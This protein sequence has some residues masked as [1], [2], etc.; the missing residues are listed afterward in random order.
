MAIIMNEYF[1]CGC[2]LG[3]WKITEDY[4]TLLSKITLSRDEL[5]TL[6]RF[7]HANRK[8]EWLSVR[9]LLSEMTNRELSIYYNGN[10]KPFIK[11][12]THMISIS[13]S[14]DLT[15]ILLNRQKKV[16]VDLEYMTNRIYRIEHKFINEQDVLT[17]DRDH[18]RQHLYLHWCAKET[19]YKI[20]DKQ[21]INFRDSLTLEHFE[22]LDRGNIRG[23]VRNLTRNEV[24][25]LN[26]F[27]LGN[28]AIVW[29]CK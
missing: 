9:V 20:C 18:L 7:T 1:D 12:N 11:E 14:R 15:A 2:H 17:Q 3:I 25:N 22:P 5:E 29:C 27:T 8:M 23:W 13:H 26:Y 19:L 21:D 24:F 10:R 4:Q 28:Y 6:D 16:G